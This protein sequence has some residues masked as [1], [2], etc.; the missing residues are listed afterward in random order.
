MSS[1]PTTGGSWTDVTALKY[2][3]DDPA[4]RDY[5]SNSSG[6]SGLV[7]GRITGLAADAAGDIWA[8]GANGGVWRR[9][10]GSNHWVAIDNG[11]LSLS[12]GDLEYSNGTLWYATGEANTGGTSYVGAGVYVLTNPA[13]S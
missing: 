1:L 11:L 13:T 8:A 6:G 4:Y 2:D 7:T 5:Y 3:A 12:S 9:T 10:A